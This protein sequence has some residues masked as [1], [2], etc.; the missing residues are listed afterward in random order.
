MR[1]DAA[2]IAFDAAD[3]LLGDLSG[4]EDQEWV[5]VWLEVHVDGRAN[6]QPADRLAGAGRR[7]PG[8]GTPRLESLL[9]GIRNDRASST[10]TLRTNGPA[11]PGFV[12]TMKPSPRPNGSASPPGAKGSVTTELVNCLGNLGQYL[13]WRGDLDEAQENLHTALAISEHAHDRACQAWC[14]AASAW[15]GPG[16][17][18]SRPYGAFHIRL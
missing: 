15:S 18:M 12:L 5:D 11:K 16:A 9:H 3:E 7:S 13:L 2:A 4:D 10:Q 14:L 17:T 6:V 8:Q 1:H